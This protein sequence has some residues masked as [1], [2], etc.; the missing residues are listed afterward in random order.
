MSDQT[1]R[2]RRIDDVG[3]TLPHN[4][5]AE[6]SVLGAILLRN[7]AMEHTRHLE[8]HHFYRP[9]HAWVYGA[10]VTLLDRPG[11]VAD[12]TTVREEL[13]RVGKLEDVGGP[14]FIAALVDGVPKSTNARHYADIVIEHA[15]LR[16]L[17]MLG[18]QVQTDAYAGD[19]RSDDIIAAADAGLINLMK[20]GAADDMVAVRGNSAQRLLD[21]VQFRVE[22]QN[23]VIGT[24]TGF[25]SIDEE[26]L[27]W[28]ASDLII[29]A[30]RPSI[31]KTTYVMNSVRHACMTRRKDG[32]FHRCAVFSIEMKKEQ[33]EQ[34][35]LAE[36]SGVDASSLRSGRIYTE[37]QWGAISQ[38][39]GTFD[40]FDLHINDKSRLTPR[41]VRS[42]CRRLK[43]EA[44]HLDLVVIDYI[45]LMTPSTTIKGDNRTSEMTRISRDLKE[46]AGELDVPMVVLSQLKR[47]SDK[48][49]KERPK[50][51]DLRESGS[52]E[53][54]AD[55]V[56]FLH[57]KD[58]KADGYTEFI[59]EKQRNGPTGT[60]ALTL[61]NSILRFTDG[62]AEPAPT[63]AEQK[64]T[65]EDKAAAKTRAIIKAQSKKKAAEQ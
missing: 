52:L 49:A 1:K 41:D 47:P 53:Q 22:H 58:H 14:A 28:N 62:G 61:N 31:G 8:A 19:Q 46:L 23:E 17:V 29:I 13:D 36:L 65:A 5:E 55:L 33:L 38:A 15:L 4:L 21:Y 45:Q 30:A 39:V 51:E 11:G 54:D 16:A 57:R 60:V 25:A 32:R 34:R 42:A 12:F 35:M 50:L 20:H 10:M 2:R 64:Q 18:T 40:E 9:S 37:Q 44:G 3:R 27:G 26:T 43:A 7:D 48:F 56:C 59:I 63:P 24:P 6:R